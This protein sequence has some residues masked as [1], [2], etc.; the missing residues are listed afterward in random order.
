LKIFICEF[1]TGGGLYREPLPSSLA[2]EGAMMRDALLKD[3]AEIPNVEVTTTH[4]AR[5]P[6]PT[7]AQSTAV[8]YA[9]DVWSIWNQH[10]ADADAVWLI[11][12]ETAGALARLS[13]MVR[14]QHKTLL[15]CAIEAVRMA[16]SKFTTSRVLR[17]A[18]VNAV[19]AYM[20]DGWPQDNPGP[21][22][23]KADDGAGCENSVYFE[24]SAALLQW[25]QG[26]E[27]THIIQP[28][29]KGIAASICM[30]C[31]EGQAWLLSCNS[32]KIALQQSGP[33]S[34]TFIYSGS[35]LNCMA[36]YWQVFEKIATQVARVM[37]DLSGCVGI[38]V[39][40]DGED[41]HVLEVN[42]RLTTSYAGLSRAMGC[43]P[44][45]MVIDLL[46]NKNFEFPQK[47]SRNIIEI[48]L[49]E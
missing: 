46:Y 25:M 39:V 8:S 38:D 43:N 13:A 10:I 21:W 6:S 24:T 40:V 37:P 2:A 48:S 32:Q 26:R 3:L 23:A 41:V 15:G 4:D 22:V 19:N 49:N 9:D 20:F 5:L 1:I 17:A 28:Y 12:P 36:E 47:I 18:G 16:A 7:C 27:A 45:Q 11:A 30:L 31:H 44:A 35:V 42:P 29:E 33:E 14:D 34:S